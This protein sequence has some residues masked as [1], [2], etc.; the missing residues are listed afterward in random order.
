MISVEKSN[1][2]FAKLS[3][4][5]TYPTIVNA[6]SRYALSMVPSFAIESVTIKKNTT[7]MNDDI[8]FERL[9][10][11]PI[12]SGFVDEFNIQEECECNF[13]LSKKTSCE[14]CTIEFECFKENNTNEVVNVFDSDFK[15]SNEKVIPS[16]MYRKKYLNEKDSLHSSPILILQLEPKQSVHF[17][18]RVCKNIGD[19]KNH[20]NYSGHIVPVIA[21]QKHA[22]QVSLKI[23]ETQ[24]RLFTLEDKQALIQGCPSKVFDLDEK[25]DLIVRDPNRCIMCRDCFKISAEINKRME[26]S[27]NTNDSKKR[28]KELKYEDPENCFIDLSV[29]NKDFFFLIE[30][31]GSMLPLHLFENALKALLKDI[32]WTILEIEKV[33]KEQT[34]YK[35]LLK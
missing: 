14:K 15:S 19:S 2:V 13:S 7:M 33:M 4:K 34:K 24:K 30:T 22:I 3:I 20:K 27:V 18:A 11:I 16:S 28:I 35:D 17:V 9:H 31:S 26:G 5:N 12:W 21:T 10:Q 6:L 23:N 32:N 25:K 1:S 29:S 8:L